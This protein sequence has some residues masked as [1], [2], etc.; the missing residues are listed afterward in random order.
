MHPLEHLAPSAALPLP[1]R[2]PSALQLHRLGA[3]H[4]ATTTARA[5]KIPVIIG[6]SPPAAPANGSPAETASRSNP[7][8][9]QPP[10]RRPAGSFL[11]QT[12]NRT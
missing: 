8:N 4:T 6:N 9:R 7:H 3:I 10:T 11:H 2:F 1:H 12:M 5:D